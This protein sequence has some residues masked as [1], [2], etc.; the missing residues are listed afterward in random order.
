MLIL[1][2]LKVIRIIVTVGLVGSLVNIW[3][4]IRYQDFKHVID[5]VYDHERIER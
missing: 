1:R 3:V 5:A 4:L 2:A